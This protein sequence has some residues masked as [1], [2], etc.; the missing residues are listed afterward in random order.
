MVATLAVDFDEPK[1]EVKPVISLESLPFKQGIICSSILLFM[2]AIT[3]RESPSGS[4]SPG[5][6][7][8]LALRSLPL[9][10]D[11]VE[12]EPKVGAPVARIFT[13]LR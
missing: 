6:G 8:R 11:G 3:E 5:T 7:S 13:S 2:R 1:S 4:G 12:L 9:P 10:S